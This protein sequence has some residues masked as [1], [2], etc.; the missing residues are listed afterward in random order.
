MR[1]APKT[2]TFSGNITNLLL[3]NLTGTT[4]LT[5]IDE[6]IIPEDLQCYCNDLSSGQ[7]SQEYAIYNFIVIIFSIPVVAIL[8]AIGN[9]INVYIFTRPRFVSFCLRFML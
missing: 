6:L 9:V 2:L 3:M 7:F 4:N 5:K 1:E 8:G